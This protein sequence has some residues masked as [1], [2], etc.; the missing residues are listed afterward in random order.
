MFHFSLKPRWD[1]RPMRRVPRSV[2]DWAKRRL[3]DWFRLVYEADKGL[4]HYDIHPHA[5]P[6]LSWSISPRS[7]DGIEVGARRLAGPGQI[8]SLT[9]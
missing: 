6:V 9:L 1:Y 7:A 5:I 8:T 4:M 2:G 3:A